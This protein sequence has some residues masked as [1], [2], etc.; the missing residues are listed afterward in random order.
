MSDNT[1]VAKCDGTCGEKEFHN[2]HLTPAGAVYY[3]TP[4]EENLFHDATSPE[5]VLGLLA[6]YASVCWDENRV[7][8][9]EKANKGV[10]HALAQL[11]TLGYLEKIEGDSEPND[12]EKVNG[13]SD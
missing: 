1:F 12:K 4:P 3:G 5:E 9:S 8:E 2:A 11:K 13:S 7:F 6:G 10:N